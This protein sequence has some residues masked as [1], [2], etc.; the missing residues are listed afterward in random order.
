MLQDIGATLGIGNMS[1]GVIMGVPVLAS[2]SGTSHN[3]EI[4]YQSPNSVRSYYS[5]GELVD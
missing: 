2:G 3:V 1:L 5:V 4:C